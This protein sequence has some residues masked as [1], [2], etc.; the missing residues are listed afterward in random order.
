M[1]SIQSVR[2]RVAETMVN[3]GL[4][5]LPEAYLDGDGNS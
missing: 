1:S 5:Y 4:D 3:L 2:N